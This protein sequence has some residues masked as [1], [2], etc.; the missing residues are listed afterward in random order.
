MDRLNNKENTVNTYLDNMKIAFIGT[1]RFLCFMSTMLVFMASIF[2]IP[3]GVFT[4][5]FFF[6]ALGILIPYYVILFFIHA[7]LVHFNFYDWM[8]K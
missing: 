6:E 8:M 7:T 4:T 2:V 1:I 3:I 5:S